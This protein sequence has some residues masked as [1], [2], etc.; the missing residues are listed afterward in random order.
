MLDMNYFELTFDD[1]DVDG[2][3]LS[4]DHE[5]NDGSWKDVWAFSS[6]QF[7]VEH[8][9]FSVN[10]YSSGSKRD[11]NIADF[12]IPVVSSR[13][14]QAVESLAPNEIQR[15]PVTIENESGW[16]IFNVLNCVDCI[17]HEKSAIDYYP[18]DP[19]EPILQQETDKAGKPRGIRSLKIDASKTLGMHIFRIKDWEVVI[20]VSQQLKNKLETDRFDG[21]KFVEL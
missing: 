17:D 15:I 16:E 18:T 19:R 13:F 1:V 20:V 4:I 21:I 6:C 12:D 14:A 3:E 2:W 5:R 9:T 8:E 11:F 7:L 10:I